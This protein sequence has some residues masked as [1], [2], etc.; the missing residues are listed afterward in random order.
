MLILTSSTQVIHI[1]IINMPRL[2]IKT[3]N[4]KF[5]HINQLSVISLIFSTYKYLYIL[6][7]TKN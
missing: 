1:T 3:I 7:N 6:Y 4:N 2:Y 5:I